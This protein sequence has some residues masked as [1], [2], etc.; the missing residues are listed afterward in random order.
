MAASEDFGNQLVSLLIAAGADVHHRNKVSVKERV[1]IFSAL[2]RHN[3]V[4]LGI[5]LDPI[6]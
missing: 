5:G 4:R 2:L 3:T 1:L 6:V